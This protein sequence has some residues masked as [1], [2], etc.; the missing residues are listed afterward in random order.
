[1]ET[2]AARY[3]A[4]A[5]NAGIYIVSACGF[6]SIPNDIGA[7]LLQRTFNGELAYVESYMNIDSGSVS[8]S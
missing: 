7:L 6:D 2:V 1:M 4:D 8:R 5:H 3:D